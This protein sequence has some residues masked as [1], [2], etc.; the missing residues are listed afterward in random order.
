MK[1]WYH[2]LWYRIEMVQWHL[3]TLREDKWAASHHYNEA[4]KHLNAIHLIELE[5]SL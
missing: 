5:E 3:A 4:T 1:K 2:K